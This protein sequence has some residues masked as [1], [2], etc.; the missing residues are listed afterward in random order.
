V[1]T[2]RKPAESDAQRIAR[3]IFEGA[4]SDA[5]AEGAW[6]LEDAVDFVIEHMT[7]GSFE[8]PRG[9]GPRPK[10]LDEGPLETTVRET[11]SRYY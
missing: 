11:L 3:Q 1:I 2:G 5:T 6:D 8:W 4:V 9:L 10:F 7:G